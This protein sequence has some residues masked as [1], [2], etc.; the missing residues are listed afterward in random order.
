[1]GFAARVVNQNDQHWTITVDETAPVE[2]IR[3]NKKGE[4]RNARGRFKLSDTPVKF[5]DFNF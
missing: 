4:W 1:M 2:R 3:L 5:Y